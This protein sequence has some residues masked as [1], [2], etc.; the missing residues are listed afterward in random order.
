MEGAELGFLSAIACAAAYSR[1]PVHAELAKVV[2]DIEYSSFSSSNRNG[3]GQEGMLEAQTG[4]G[5]DQ[6]HA[7]DHDDGP[8]PAREIC[9]REEGSEVYVCGMQGARTEVNNCRKECSSHTEENWGGDTRS[10][11]GAVTDKKEEF[12]LME[13][14][15]LHSYSE[16]E[17]VEGGNHPGGHMVRITGPC[18][19]PPRQRKEKVLT[20]LGDSTLPQRRRSVR[21]CEKQARSTSSKQHR[22]GKIFASISDG[23]INNCNSRLCEQGNGAEPVDLWEIGK[24]TGLFCHGDEEE[25]VQEYVCMEER[26]TE[27][28]KHAKDGD[29]DGLS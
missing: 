14:D 10:L 15:E 23:D 13:K 8:R 3:L 2:V 25:V 9:G 18:T 5:W 28:A 7:S 26:D 6:T 22:E 24:T 11:K 17:D 21:L 20:E 12:G 27:V 29:K 1:S 16:G 4:V 19:S